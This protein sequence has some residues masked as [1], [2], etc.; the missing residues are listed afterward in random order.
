MK[1]FAKESNARFGIAAVTSLA[2]GM[3]AGSLHAQEKQANATSERVAEDDLT[4]AE[5][6]ALQTLGAEYGS[7]VERRWRQVLSEDELVEG[8]NDRNVFIASGLATVAMQKGRAGWIES[9]RVA[10]DVAFARAKADLVAS[11][12]Q[13]IQREGSASFT[14]NANFGQGQ[15][16]QVEAIDQTARI[17]QKSTDLTEETLD[18]A[19]RE[20]DPE[21]DPAQYEDMKV[22]ERKVALENIFEQSSY[23]A[24]ARV[25]S[26]ATIYRIIEGPSADGN[27][28]EVLVAMVWSPRLSSLAAAIRDGQT[29]MPV[30]GARSSVDAM[31]PETV[32]D[33]VASLGTRVFIDENGDR[34]LI[35]FA[36]AEPVEVNPNA[37]DVAR[38]SAISTAEDLAIGQIANF[39]GESVSLESEATS[40]QITQV[41]ADLVQRGVEINTKQVQTIRTASGRVNVTGVQPVWRQVVQHP[42]TE[43]DMAI[44]AAVWSPSS[45]AMG[46]RMGGAMDAARSSE[47]ANADANDTRDDAPS[48]DEDEM[49]FE[50]EPVDADAF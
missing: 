46:E 10:F 27:N 20:L 47:A 5:S 19:L 14:T 13:T 28:H 30:D 7:E 25:I 21:Y 40:D 48:T 39:V 34:A 9:R 44:V 18:A 24:A 37:L 49:T 36:Q 4:A 3:A 17:L 8:E 12:G 6:R 16:Q 22:P 43:Q 32:G 23:R 38:R 42:E 1:F 31:L 11:M 29:T 33:A 26:G 2:I 50:S 45:Q 15:I 35:S 41:Y